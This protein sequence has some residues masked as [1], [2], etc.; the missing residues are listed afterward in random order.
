MAKEAI[1]YGWILKRGDG[2]LAFDGKSSKNCLLLG[3]FLAE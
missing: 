3:L 2:L 1:G